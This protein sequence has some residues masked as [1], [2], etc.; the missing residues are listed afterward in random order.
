MVEEVQFELKLIGKVFVI[1]YK[2]YNRMSEI[3]Y[4]ILFEVLF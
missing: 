1:C 4:C 3:V 2:S